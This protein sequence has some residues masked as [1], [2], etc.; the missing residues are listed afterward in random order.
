MADDTL[1]IVFKANRLSA[2]FLFAFCAFT[3][4]AGIMKITDD[5]FRYSADHW[6][7]LTLESSTSG[8]LM[9]AVCL[10]VGLVALTIVVRGC[11]RLSLGETGI[12]VGQCFRAPVTISWS[13]LADVT[14]MRAR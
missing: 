11:P 5:S 7:P 1:P 13:D 8:W 4:F 3:V 9:V 10:P 14:V 2:F 12:V 6:G